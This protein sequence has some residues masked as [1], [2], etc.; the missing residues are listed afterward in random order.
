MRRL[1][2]I[3]VNYNAGFA[4]ANNVAVDLFPDFEWVAQFSRL[5]QFAEKRSQKSHLAA[6]TL[7]LC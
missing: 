1:A 6:W 4:N 5:L 7:R 2:V 3:V